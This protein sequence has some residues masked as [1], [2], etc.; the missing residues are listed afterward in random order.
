[1]AATNKLAMVPTAC[2]YC[3]EPFKQQENHRF[4][5]RAASGKLYCSEFCAAD[6]EVAASRNL[7]GAKWHL[8]VNDSPK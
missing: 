5:W 7:G 6:D 1:M 4:A 3:G 2:A 8:P